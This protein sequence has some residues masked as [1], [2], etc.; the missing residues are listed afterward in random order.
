LLAVH[1]LLQ[2]VETHK[3]HA[4]LPNGFQ[5]EVHKYLD[6]HG[7]VT[8]ELQTAL[9]EFE[10]HYAM[11]FNDKGKADFQDL[12]AEIGGK[13]TGAIKMPRDQTPFWLLEKGPFYNYRSSKT[14]PKEADVVI[15]GAGLTGSSAAYYLSDFAKSGKKSCGSRSGSDCFTVQW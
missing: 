10:K 4:D 13:M 15:I 5:N 3:P 14:F 1:P 11:L 7:R 12:L 9:T 2:W 8:E 6:S